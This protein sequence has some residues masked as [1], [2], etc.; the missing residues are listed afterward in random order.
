MVAVD[1]VVLAA[2]ALLGFLVL[3]L[4]RSNAELTRAM[5]S[6]G[7]DLSPDAPAGSGAAGASAGGVAT[8]VALQARPTPARPD[9][10]AVPDL[11]GVTPSGDAVAIAVTGVRHD[12]LVA[13][14]TSGCSTCRGIWDVLKQGVPDVPGGARLVV[15]TRG[16]EAESPGVVA[17]LAGTH[18]PVVMSSDVWSGYDVPYAPY[19]VYVSGP[20][21]RVVGEGTAATWD[22]VRTLVANAVA[23]GTTNPVAQP[24]LGERWAKSSADADREQRIDRELA[25]AGILP[26]D[27]R[28]RPTSITQPAGPEPGEI[29]R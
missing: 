3:G 1:V 29:R 24:D 16:S 27:P 21:A 28:L 6:L 10:T 25:A 18:V 12:T 8:P 26:G 22:A 14:L 20:A 15:V 23:D 5:H 4:L 2:V 9:P 7:V 13:F 17:G 19:F 11:A